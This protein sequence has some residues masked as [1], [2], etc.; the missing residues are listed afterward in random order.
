MQQKDMDSYMT[1]YGQHFI[2]S[3][4]SCHT[5]LEEVGGM[6]ILTD[7]ISGTAFG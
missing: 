1:N 3:H 4:N 5:H 2:V 6:H 7:H